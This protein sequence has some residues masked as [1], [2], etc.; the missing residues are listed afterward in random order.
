MASWLHGFER[1]GR[2]SLAQ[3]GVGSDPQR[4]FL[5]NI[6]HVQ[7]VS[8]RCANLTDDGEAHKMHSTQE[9]DDVSHSPHAGS[10]GEYLTAMPQVASAKK[11]DDAWRSC[12]TQM[13][14]MER[15]IEQKMQLK[16]GNVA[17]KVKDLPRRRNF[18]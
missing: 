10:K 16:N 6:W 3:I 9:S 12:A 17:S 18:Q 13:E 1:E 14:E 8:C 5:M 4:L 15:W 2:M 7:G 11:P